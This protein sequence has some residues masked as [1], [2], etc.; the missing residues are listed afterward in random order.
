MK[1]IHILPTDKPSNIV[2]STIDGKLKLNNNTN[3]SVEYHGQNQNIYITNDEEIKVGD[4][5][6]CSIS[7]AP[8]K[9]LQD[10]NYSIKNDWEKIIL[11]TD[12]DLIDDNIQAI[13][14]DF[15]EWF[16]KNPSCEFVEVERG[17]GGMNGFVKSSEPI[18][19][20]KLEYKIIISKEEP[21]QLYTDYPII[22][23]GDEEFKEAPIRECELLSYD[24]NKYCYVK[25]EGI[26][27]EIKRC[28]IYSQ[29]GRCGE[30]DC[31]SIEEIKELL[32]EEPKILSE[33]GQELFFD[34]QGY[35]IKEEPKL[36]NVCIKCGVDLYYAPNFTCQEHPKNCK[37]I[38]LSEETLKQRALKEEPKQKC[39]VTKSMQIDA[40]LAYKSLPKQDALNHF[41]S[42]S[43]VIVKDLQKWDFDKQ[44][45]LEEVAE[46]DGTIIQF[47]C[48]SHSYDGVWFG[49]LHPNKKGTFWW[50]SILKEWQ[51]EQDNKMYSEEEVLNILNEFCDNFYENSIRKDVIEKW[52]EKFKQEIS[53]GR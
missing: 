2:I 23:L 16:V 18:S 29:K 33:N 44:E 28:Y 49:N 42:T 52:L 51:Q 22:E 10:E 45:T 34:K 39:L 26:E 40:E 38:H 15:L 37:G 6:L 7:T 1:N 21:K 11:T 53:D 12:Q 20:D 32:K 13:D 19:K 36:T 9:A 8:T 17:Y 31:V 48:G 3:D 43:S 30:V 41:L 4:W 5:I 14:D 47:L 46:K 35:L 25:V 27:K 50:R 24:D